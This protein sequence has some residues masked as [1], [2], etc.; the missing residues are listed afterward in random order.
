MKKLLIIALAL[1]SVSIV[2]AD[3]GM[4]LLSKLKP[5]NIEK[6]QQMG[7]KLT[8]EDIYDVNKPGIK[9][10][11]VGLGNAGRPF[12][13]FCS[14][15]IISPNGL[16]LTNH[17]CGF[18]AIQSHSSVEHDYLA[19]GF[20]AYKMEDELTN[21]GVTASIL[22]RM[23][24]VTDRIAPFLKDDM[25][26]MD[27]GAIIDSISAVIV[28]EAVAGTKLSGQVQPMF[29]GN[30][31]FLFLYTIYK[32]VRLVG[33]PPQ[34]MGKFGGDTDNWMWPRH[35]ADFSMFRIYTAPDGS[36]AEYSKDNVPLKPKHY[37]P[38]SAKGVKDGDFA[39]IMGFPGTTDRYTT[40]F[41]LQNTMDVTND[42]RYKVRTVKLEV[43]REEMAKSPKTRI[44]YASKYASCANYWK[45]SFEQNKA[46]KNLNTKGNKEAIEREFTAWVNAD[47]ARKATYGEVL[48]MIRQGYEDIKEYSV[49]TAYAQEALAGPE[50]HLFAYRSGRM[51]EDLCDKE[52]P[53]GE[54]TEIKEALKD[55]AKA[56]FK[57]YNADL[58]TKL[59]AALFKIYNDNV[60]PDLY[61]E[62]IDL[63]NK[64]YKGN[65]DKFAAGLQQKSIFM[66]EAAFNA[67][68]DKPDCKQL[69]KDP[70]FPRIKTGTI[71][72]WKPAPAS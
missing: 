72:L 33:A 62:V 53:A 26:E 7:F 54:K 52:I 50:A 10:A 34:S 59:F 29:E 27:R 22:E 17:H 12:R 20:W 6:M 25:S 23:E 67:F 58:D 1:L 49:A 37:L 36:P 42:I 57:D 41:G 16:M 45:Y 60:D 40:S 19:D 2:R 8:A 30:Q 48:P 3:E 9:D 51:I 32:D 43:M 15:E 71:F 47:P 44:Q 66:D 70:V 63:V 68:L 38:V 13:H 11:I 5:L 64:K 14:G 28:K 61:P 46:L 55:M 24:D 4:W 69:A 35:T 31:F 39:M 18:S 56:F 65:Y 21:P